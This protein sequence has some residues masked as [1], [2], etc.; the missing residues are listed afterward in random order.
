MNTVLRPSQFKIPV[1][2]S[3]YLCPPLDENNK[4]NEVNVFINEY[5]STFITLSVNT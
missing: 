4:V 1:I 2:Y 5:P 3:E